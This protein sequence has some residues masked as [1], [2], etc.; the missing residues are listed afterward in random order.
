MKTQNPLRFSAFTLIELLVVIAIIAI[1]AAILFPVFGRARENAR[2]TS[3]LSNLKQLSLGVLQYTQDFDEAF[4][5]AAVH[6]TGFST[7]PPYVRPRGWADAIYPYT[8]SLQI[9]QC[10]SERQDGSAD[11]EDSMDNAGG[12]IDYTLNRRLNQMRVARAA[13][14]S[15]SVLLTEGV[16]ASSQAT[17]EG[18]I[19]SVTCASTSAGNRAL[20]PDTGGNW[21]LKTPSEGRHM[22]GHNVSFCDGHAKWYKSDTFADLRRPGVS[23]GTVTAPSNGTLYTYHFRSSTIYSG[24]TPFSTS[25]NTPTYNVD[26]QQ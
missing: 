26:I 17:N 15:V 16:G 21:P 7:S 3:C 8:K 4:P 2:R 22:G 12:F 20:M 23:S 1:L 13:N 19:V 25:G 14:A 24:V 5:S 10:P 11:P 6:S 18:C 9:N